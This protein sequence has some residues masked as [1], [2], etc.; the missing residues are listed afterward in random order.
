MKKYLLFGLILA[1]GV[2]LFNVK[3]NFAKA[4]GDSIQGCGAGANFNILTGQPC[5]SITQ[6]IECAPGHLFSS[7]TGRPC[8]GTT[9]IPSSTTTTATTLST[10]FIFTQDLSASLKSKGDD[11]LALQRILKDKGYFFGKVDGKF[12]KVTG[13]AVGDYQED[14]DLTRTEIVDAATRSVLN[15]GATITPVCSTTSTDSNGCNA[16]VISGVSGPQT[17]NVNQTGTWAVKAYSSNGGT[18]SYTVDWGDNTYASPNVASGAFIVNQSSTFTH[19]YSNAGIYTPKFTVTLGE[20]GLY[21]QT[22]LSVS[23]GS[24]TNSSGNLTVA[25][26]A[27]AP[28]SQFLSIGNAGATNFTKVPF[29]FYSTGE[30]LTVKELN[31]TISKPNTVFA[32]TVTGGATAQVVSGLAHLTGLNLVV[33]ANSTL[34]LDVYLSYRGVGTNGIPSGTMSKIT[35]TSVKYVSSSSGIVSTLSPNISSNSM[36]LVGSVPK[37]SLESPSSLVLVPGSV[38]LGHVKISTVGGGAVTINQI[39]IKVM[40]T[41]ASLPSA[42]WQSNGIVVKDADTGVVLYT[43]NAAFTTSTD[44]GI[45]IITFPNGLLIPAGTTRTL[46]IYLTVSI[47]TGNITSSLSLNLSIPDLFS[48]TDTA[49]GASTPMNSIYSSYLSNYPTDT[50]TLTGSGGVIIPIPTITSILPPGCSSSSGYSA[51]NGEPCSSGIIGEFVYVNGSNFD[52]GNTVLTYSSITGNLITIPVNFISSNQLSFVIPTSI[53]TGLHGFRINLVDSYSNTV[54][55]NITVPATPIQAPTISSIL[56]TSG[57]VGTQ[58]TINGS[59]FISTNLIKFG[60]GTLSA[61][62]STE[63]SMTFTIPSYLGNCSLSGACTNAMIMI[64]PDTTYPVS[65][66]NSNGISN[67]MNFTVISP[68]VPSG[69][70]SI[71][72]SSVLVDVNGNVRVKAMYSPGCPTSV[73]VACRFSLQEVN[74]TWNIDNTSIA[75]LVQATPDCRPGVTCSSLAYASVTGILSGT[76]SLKA[77]Y[78]E[79]GGNVITAIVP[80]TVAGKQAPVSGNVGGADLQSSAISAFSSSGSSTTAQVPSVEKFHFTQFLEQG[81]YGNEVKELQKFL[82]NS[83]Y[84]VGNV[85]SVF[86]PKVKESLIKFQTDNHLKPDGIFGYEMRTFL[87]K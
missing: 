39:P 82:N 67:T 57:A 31:F 11:V 59:G 9:T 17:L 38:D 77:T 10:N 73:G 56:P 81:S 61:D 46:K 4:E 33:P 22:S 83:G 27:S 68:A 21:A 47:F 64:N 69:T 58:V 18:L 37:L 66:M 86:G 70:L 52:S 84:D 49:G 72:P 41:Y 12:G 71:D 35:L 2:G 87:N 51:A 7:V 63:N 25:L 34:N 76:T 14:N 45:A 36:I 78:T 23:V 20:S 8:S 54:S 60:S 26:D 28:S 19:S 40:M 62:S 16:P 75:N 6:T 85:D 53:G 1:F 74:V 32:V 29:K 65:V 48:W 50:I 5:H 80:I 24:T 55:F 15:G 44:G 43:T 42:S 3:V 79:S 30:A 13:R